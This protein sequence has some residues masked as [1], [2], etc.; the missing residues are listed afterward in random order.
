MLRLLV[1]T[2]HFLILIVCRIIKFILVAT[3]LKEYF[4]AYYH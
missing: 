3:I 1:E 4:R 2:K